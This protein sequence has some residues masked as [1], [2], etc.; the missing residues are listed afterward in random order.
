M[1]GGA[2]I[3]SESRW[4][5]SPSSC[6]LAM[7]PVFASAGASRGLTPTMMAA[8]GALVPTIIS[9]VFSLIYPLALILV[10]SSRPVRAYYNSM[11]SVEA[12][13]AV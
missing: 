11:G 6:T 12:M 5:D 7:S 9:A 10:F 4:S 3:T 1:M 8:A 13:P 2:K